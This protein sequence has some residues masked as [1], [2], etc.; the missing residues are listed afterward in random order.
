[1]ERFRRRSSGSRSGFERRS[2]NRRGR[3][4]VPILIVVVIVVKLI[5]V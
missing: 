3:V 4:L 2:V 1:M 5:A